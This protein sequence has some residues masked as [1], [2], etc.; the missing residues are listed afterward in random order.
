MEGFSKLQDA[1]IS[2]F[3]PL[4]SES[5][6]QIT[7]LLN[8]FPWRSDSSSWYPLVC[9]YRLIGVEARELSIF[10]SKNDTDIIPVDASILL[11]TDTA[12]SGLL[13][14]LIL[15]IRRLTPGGNK[16]YY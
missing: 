9:K 4:S 3:I 7:Q 14:Q 11:T 10:T 8:S 13:V 15:D 5:H 12:V 16:S 2:K 6:L 1:D